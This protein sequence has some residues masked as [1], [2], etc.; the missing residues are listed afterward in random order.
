MKIGIYISGLGQS[1]RQETVVKYTTRLMNE[2]SYN[3]TGINYEIKTE[4]INYCAAKESNVVSIIE[5]N[6]G[7]RKPIFKM[8]DFEYHN[9][10][11]DKFS[12]SNIFIRSFSL[13]FLVIKKIPI[14][15]KRMFISGHYNQPVQTFYIFLMFFAVAASI[16]FTIPAVLQIMFN[17]LSTPEVQKYVPLG[18]NAEWI[19]TSTDIF[20]SFVA[21]V[22]VL[23]PMSRS[24]VTRLSTEFICINDY[25]EF[26]AQSQEVLGNLDLLVEY[27]AE[28]EPDSKIQYHTYSCGSIIAIDYLF[29][30]GNIPSGNSQKLSELLITIGSPYE[31]VKAYYPHFYEKRNSVLEKN[32]TWVN[33]YSI[34]DAL[35]TNFRKDATRGEAQFGFP[36]FQNLKPFNINYEVSPVKG[37]NLVNFLSLYNLKVHNMY[38]DESV[39]GQS[40]LRLIHNE[41]TCRNL[42]Y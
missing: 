33:V 28:N 1:F 6:G 30:F 25:I 34:A 26:G 42:L 11:T 7:I 32:I 10:L 31:F 3:N 24:F 13:L 29:Q 19:R 37:F 21:T 2:I 35:A 20:V 38:W 5:N 22:L 8:Y 14:L 18:L 23:L 39:E 17:A 27:I 16:L 40:C 9:I 12:N 41:L 4:K 15:I 36:D